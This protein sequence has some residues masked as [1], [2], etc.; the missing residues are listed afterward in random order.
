LTIGADEGSKIDVFKIC[1][2]NRLANYTPEKCEV[3]GEGHSTTGMS[4]ALDMF[5]KSF[6]YLKWR[7]ERTLFLAILGVA[8]PLHKPYMLG[9]T[10]MVGDV[11]SVT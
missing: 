4:Q 5:T 9:S 2:L 10:E 3:S 1:L 8:F 7:Y 6:M 11:W